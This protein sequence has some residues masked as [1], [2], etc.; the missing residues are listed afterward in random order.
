MNEAGNHGGNDAGETEATLLF[1]SPKFRTMLPK[2]RYECPTL[3]KEG[4]R[5]DYY[6]KVEQQDLVPTLSG[7]MGLPIPRNSI[8]KVLS[9]LRGVWLS[10][11]SYVSLLEEN[12]RQL[13]NIA[14]NVFGSAAL[15][16]RKQTITAARNQDADQTTCADDI[17]VAGRLVCLLISADQRTRDSKDTQ[18]WAE[19]STAYEEFLT[20]AQ[21]V[22]I[23]EN[24]S[25]SILCMGSGIFLCAAAAVLCWYGIGIPGSSGKTSILFV[26]AA[27]SY[28]ATLLTSTTERSERYFWHTFSSI[29]TLSLAGRAGSDARDTQTHSRIQRASIEILAFHCIAVFWTLFERLAQRTLFAESTA[30]LWLEVLAVY[31][32]SAA[33]LLQHTFAGVAATGTAISLVIP[34]VTTAF[35]FKINHELEQS[36]ATVLPIFVDQVFHFRTF[37]VLLV[38]VTMVVCLLVARRSPK[39][40]GQAAITDRTLSSRLH[41]L[42][43]LFLVTQSKS[44]NSLLFIGMEHQRKCLETILYSDP[45]PPRQ[46]LRPNFSAVDIAV[47]VFTFS[48]TY[49][50]CF[51]GSNSISSIDLSNAYNGISDYHILTVAILL[52]SA[53]WTGPIWWCS[54]V[55]DLVPRKP[56]ARS[57]KPLKLGH[58]DQ[59][60]HKAYERPQ[61][62]T[63]S[64]QDRPESPWL[65]YLST[66]SACM[67]SSVLVV[68]IL[69]T[70]RRGSSA[71]WTLWGSKYLYAV[72]WVLEWHLV[73]SLGLSSGLRAL[74]SR[75]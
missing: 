56:S 52:F 30:L 5:Y 23:K 8:G 65:T 59:V 13:W 20:Q 21:R 34:L 14:Q 64:I 54:A 4:T 9:A 57:D 43:T 2:E 37:L 38:L 18:Q 49:F 36:H 31:G 25:F 32:W 42:L 51:G 33:T 17:G 11:E 6:S 26:L 66:I 47:T 68:M 46:K 19:A 1:A 50:F 71:V 29:W 58:R 67:A 15:N 28:A 35:L 74:G 16:A 62:Q 39:T 24:Q 12:A 45:Q 44:T 70:V 61:K 69:C 60:A 7:L 10:D 3:P 55:C 27:L 63:A 41:H 40:E 73:V 53:N 22:L 48:H 72:F 75:Q